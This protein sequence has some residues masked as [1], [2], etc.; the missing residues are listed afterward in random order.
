MASLLGAMLP[1][2]FAVFQILISFVASLLFLGHLL[3]IPLP[4]PLYSA[5]GLS[6]ALI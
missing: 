5:D 2:F 1:T 3:A 4:L 6:N